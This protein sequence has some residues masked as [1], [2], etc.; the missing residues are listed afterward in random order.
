MGVGFP[1][2]AARPALLPSRLDTETVV[3]SEALKNY[4]GGAWIEP[5]RSGLLPVENPSTGGILAQVPLSTP[6]AVDRAIEAAR[7]FL[8]RLSNEIGAW[9]HRRRGFRGASWAL[10]HGFARRWR[11]A[12]LARM[13]WKGRFPLLI[14]RCFAPLGYLAGRGQ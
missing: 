8:L 11:R 3:Q 13:G 5:E 9:P 7:K 6:A 12:H 1:A 4:V 2:S 10:G 14:W